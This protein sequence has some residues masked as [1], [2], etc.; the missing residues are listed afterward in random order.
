MSNPSIAPE[1][2]GNTSLIFN[3]DV[4]NGNVPAGIILTSEVTI[5]GYTLGQIVA[6]LKRCNILE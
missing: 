6:A 4:Q 5:G 1:S 3:V 2:L